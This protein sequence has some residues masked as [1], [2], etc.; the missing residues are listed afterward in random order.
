MNFVML[1]IFASTSIYAS[2]YS[3]REFPTAPDRRLTPGSICDRPDSYRYPERIAY[4]ERDSMDT[5]VKDEVFKEYRI[6]GYR[7]TPERRSDYKIDH[8]IPLCAGG[9][10][11]EDNLWP[12]HK[13]LYIKTDPIEPLGCDKLK[14]GKISQSVLINLIISAKMNLSLVQPTMDYLR[15]L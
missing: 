13:T 10:N 2:N 8:L 7:L 9:S 14:Q 6:Y 3:V 4:C 12:Q 5:R 15:R 11:R 1:L